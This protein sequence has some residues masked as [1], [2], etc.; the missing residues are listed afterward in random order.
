V[1]AQGYIRH[2]RVGVVDEA[3]WDEEFKPLYEQLIG[4]S[5]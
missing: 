5:Q 4:E 2:R 3:I 1:D